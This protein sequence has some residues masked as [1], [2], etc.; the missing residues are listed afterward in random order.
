M[1]VRTQSGLSFRVE[2][3]KNKRK[4]NY[5]GELTYSFRLLKMAVYLSVNQLIPNGELFLFL[6]CPPSDDAYSKQI[7]T[8]MKAL[9]I[10]YFVPGVLH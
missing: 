3:R 4:T 6:M 8:Q 1:I 2:N 7:Q 5:Q 9:F 10:F